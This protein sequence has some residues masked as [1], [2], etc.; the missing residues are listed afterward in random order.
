MQIWIKTIATRNRQDP[1]NQL[2]NIKV[3][4]GDIKKMYEKIKKYVDHNEIKDKMEK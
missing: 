4:N 2:S 3:E 1:R